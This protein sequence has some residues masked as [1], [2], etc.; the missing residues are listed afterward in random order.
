MIPAREGGTA[1]A[2]ARPA[3]RCLRLGGPVG[4]LPPIE[5]SRSVSGKQAI[6]TGVATSTNAAGM[7]GVIEDDIAGTGGKNQLGGSS[8]LRGGAAENYQS[9]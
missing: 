8:L 3:G 7:A 1:G 4:A 5:G 2:M 9:Q 6:V